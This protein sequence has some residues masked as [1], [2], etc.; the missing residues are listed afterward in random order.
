VGSVVA[1]LGTALCDRDLDVR[2]AAANTI[3]ILALTA[4]AAKSPDERTKALTIVRQAV[5]ELARAV[6][7]GDRNSRVAV[8]RAIRYTGVPTGEAA[9]VTQVLTGVLAHPDPKVRQAV[10]ETLGSMG[11]AA[12]TATDALTAALN[13]P[14]D[15]VRRA[16]SDALLKIK[17]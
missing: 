16:A 15:Y 2:E 3:S 6:Q 5:P 10:A 8:L 13:D 1:G 11:S 7:V 4:Y 17:R 14:D 12:A 9:N